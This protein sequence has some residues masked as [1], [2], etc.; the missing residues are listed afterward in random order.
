MKKNNFKK[1][2]IHKEEPQEI[3]SL[4]WVDKNKFK[5]ILA[6]IDN[7][8]FDYKDKVILSILKLKTW[9][10]ILVIIQLMKYLLK[11]V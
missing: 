2:N 11:K 1:N 4:N 6:I 9:L 5:E 8:E 7:S 10:I 3:K